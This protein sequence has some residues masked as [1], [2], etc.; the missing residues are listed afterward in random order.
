M[1]AAFYFLPVIELPQRSGY[2][3]KRMKFFSGL[4]LDSILKTLKAIF[5]AWQGG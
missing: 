1:Q 3:D 5:F 4:P 2:R